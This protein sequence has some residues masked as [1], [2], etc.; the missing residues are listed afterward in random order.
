MEQT[1]KE[2]MELQQEQKGINDEKATE[3]LKEKFKKRAST[4]FMKVA[5]SMPI[6]KDEKE[7]L[8]QEAE[9]YDNDD[10]NKII[11]DFEETQAN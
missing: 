5:D 3:D 6:K 2:L 10:L 7:A 1:L 9:N 11:K 4:V 8:A